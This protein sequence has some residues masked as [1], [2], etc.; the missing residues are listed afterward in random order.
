MSTTIRSPGASVTSAAPLA[1][2]V[3]IATGTLSGIGV[4]AAALLEDRGER[5]RDV[6]GSSV[7]RGEVRLDSPQTRGAF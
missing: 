6:S 1:G 3:A 5:Q 2:R 4:A 7:G